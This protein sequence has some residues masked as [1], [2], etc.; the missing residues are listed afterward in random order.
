MKKHFYAALLLVVIALFS[1]LQLN[2][3]EE[4]NEQHWFCWEESANP[5]MIDEYLELCNELVEL[6]KQENYPFPYYTWTRDPM[7]FERWTPINS[8]NDIDVIGDEWEKILK[9]WGDEKRVAHEKTML[10]HYSKTVS[11]QSELFYM[12]ENPEHN[13]YDWTYGRWIEL[14]LKPGNMEDMVSLFKWLNEQRASYGIQ[15]HIMVAMA[16]L[17][18][19]SPGLMVYYSQE[20]Q[21]SFQDYFD[22]TPDAYKEKFQEYL[23]KM[24]KLLLQ[25]PKIY[26]YNYIEELSYEPEGQ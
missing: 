23:A 4:K 22:S 20:S 25:P 7:V 2:A 10:K 17:G 3:Q 12:P 5:A 1:L 6:C 21:Q 18:Y 8:L 9:I 24:R 19:Q 16:G 26:H 11:M 15:D 14:Y 13:G